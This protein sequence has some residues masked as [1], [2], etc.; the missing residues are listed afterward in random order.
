MSVRLLYVEDDNDLRAMLKV[1]LRREGY[2]VTAVAAAEDAIV[3]LQTGRY[4]LLLTDYNLAN[5]NAN[6]MLQVAR[7][8][9]YLQNVRVVVLSATANPAGVENYHFLR[10]PVDVSVLFAALDE[11]VTAVDRSEEGC[12]VEAWDGTTVALTLYVTG[13]SRDAQKALRNL[14]RVT[15]K[16]DDS[17]IRL[18]VCDVTDAS[19]H[20]SN[21]LEED[22][23]VVTPT[24]VRR[25]PL[26][27]LWIFGDL[28]QH[29]AVEDLI[30]SGLDL[31]HQMP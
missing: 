25:R 26:P 23:V 27:K 13:A 17:R 16:F 10:K 8:S 5:Q 15:R 12:E 30:V 20:A 3:E 11:A 21:L 4:Q 31:I 29:E 24:L 22:R 2:D 6:W 28:S 18:T 9:G 14:R 7:T 19:G 1:L